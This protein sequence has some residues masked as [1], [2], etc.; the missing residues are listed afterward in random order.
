MQTAVQIFLRYSEHLEFYNA[1]PQFLHLIVVVQ[2]TTKPTVIY[3]VTVVRFG[4]VT[5][6]SCMLASS[7]KQRRISA[8]A[9]LC[10]G[11]HSGTNGK[12]GSRDEQL[13]LTPW[14]K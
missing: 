3:L 13:N 4:R 11:S 7:K 14:V 6:G 12:A 8:R 5:V 9:K 1:A 2:F 10:G